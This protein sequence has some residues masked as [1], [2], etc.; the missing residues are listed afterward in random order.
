MIEKVLDFPNKAAEKDFE[1]LP[2]KQRIAFLTELLLV[3]RGEKPEMPFE[4]I[5]GTKGIIELKINGSPAWRCLYYNKDPEKVW[6]LH[7]FKK[8]TN[9]ADTKNINLANKRLKLIS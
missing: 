3:L 1:S 4:H 6:V 2:Q 8:T 7:T 5:S 9:G